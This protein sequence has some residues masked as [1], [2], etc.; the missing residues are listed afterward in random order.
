MAWSIDDLD[1][2][3]QICASTNPIGVG[4]ATPLT[5]AYNP[6]NG[7]LHTSSAAL[8]GDPIMYPAPLATV[9]IG[10][11]GIAALKGLPA[12]WVQGTGLS[13]DIQL[14]G[15]LPVGI[16]IVSTF[17]V[18]TGGLTWNGVKLFNGA[19]SKTAAQAKVGVKAR[20]GAESKN[21]PTVTSGEAT[22]ITQTRNDGLFTSLQSRVTVLEARTVKAFDI[23][24]PSKDKHRLRYICL[25][26][27][28]SGVYVRGKLENENVIEL[29]YYWKDLVYPESITVNLTPIGYH[30]ELFVEE[31][32]E[33]TKI[34]IKNNSEN[35][36]KCYY[37]VFGERITKDRLQ[38]EYE[39][40]TPYDY[41]GNNEDYV[42][43][44]WDYATHKN[45]NK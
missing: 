39:G 14:G 22:G 6:I 33:G 1:L 2:S 30:Q 9:M 38:P 25:E 3:G 13:N 11:S 42:I 41:P 43:A 37:T 27:P 19:E 44:G 36:V 10:K 45:N 18:G 8:F 4:P 15:P 17:T 35:P 34:K 20:A 7:L 40:I 28:E 26:G 32:E 24:H 31:I 21:G 16:T 23:P 29:P 5:P 12:V